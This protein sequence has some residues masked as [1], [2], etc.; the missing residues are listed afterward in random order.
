MPKSLG[1]D[2]TDNPPSRLFVR[3]KKKTCKKRKCAKWKGGKCNCCR[4]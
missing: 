1:A 4:N 3:H 2:F